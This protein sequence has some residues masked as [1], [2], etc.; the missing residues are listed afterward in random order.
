MNNSEGPSHGRERRQD[1]RH[2]CSKFTEIFVQGR[3]YLGC[4]KNE[5]IGGI[6]IETN[7]SFSV[8]QQVSV[9]YTSAVGL[10]QNK[11]GKIVVINPK[12]V[13]VKFHWPGYN[14]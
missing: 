7:G 4:I 9:V 10:D 5:S 14:R 8:G 13:G 12:G 2:S 1:I 6:F 3:G 11:T